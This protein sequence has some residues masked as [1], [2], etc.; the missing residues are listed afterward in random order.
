[1]AWIATVLS[2]VGIG[3]AAW[4]TRINIQ[5]LDI[6]RDAQQAAAIEAARA[7]ARNQLRSAG[8]LLRLLGLLRQEQGR[9]N[10]EENFHDVQVSMRAELVIGGL[11][12]PVTTI[13]SERKYD[14]NATVDGPNWQSFKVAI[15][16][17]REELTM[18]AAGIRT[19]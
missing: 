2:L 19:V 1:V 11:T 18:A 16:A 12:L 6:A 14:P 4:A 13:L 17:A 10:N 15:N 5:A 8:A 3:F 7:T 9:P